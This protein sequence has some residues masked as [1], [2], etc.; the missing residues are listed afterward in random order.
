MIIH[1]IWRCLL[2]HTRSPYS[3]KWRDNSSVCPM[4][5]ADLEGLELNIIKKVLCTLEHLRICWDIVSTHVEFNDLLVSVICFCVFCW[6]VFSVHLF[7]NCVCKSVLVFCG[8][9][10]RPTAQLSWILFHLNQKLSPLPLVHRSPGVCN[11]RISPSVG[12]LVYLYSVVLDQ[13]KE[14]LF[15]VARVYR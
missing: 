15:W 3:A 14:S 11:N 1:F 13:L 8:T 6:F 12:C 4:G 10:S 7:Y 2:R 5:I 9:I